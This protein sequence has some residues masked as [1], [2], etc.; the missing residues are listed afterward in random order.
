[1]FTLIDLRITPSCIAGG[2][3]L[4]HP[5]R[6]VGVGQSGL[7]PHG[8]LPVSGCQHVHPLPLRLHCGEVHRY[9]P[10]HEGP[11]EQHMYNN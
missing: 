11:G 8:L 9:L 4:P 10:P 3:L 1:M 7:L 5:G 2:S 6:Q